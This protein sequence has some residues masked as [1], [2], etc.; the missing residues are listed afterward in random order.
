MREED[1]T[2]EQ[3]KPPGCTMQLLLG[4]WLGPKAG[5]VNKEVLICSETDI[6][7]VAKHCF[8]HLGY[9]RT[10]AGCGL[11]AGKETFPLSL[12]LLENQLPAL[13][14]HCLA[15]GWMCREGPERYFR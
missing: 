3:E 8:V 10:S 1:V 5:N 7:R 6:W 13:V 4:A 11:C 12:S 2:N 15:Q 14:K 9:C